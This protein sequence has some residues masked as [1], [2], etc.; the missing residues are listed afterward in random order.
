MGVP[1]DLKAAVIARGLADAAT[2]WR[3]LRGGRTNRVW[4]VGEVVVKLVLPDAANPVFANDATHE[5]AAL[6]ALQG[7]GIAPDPVALVPLSGADAVVYRYLPGRC[8][9][10]G[11]EAVAHLLRRL[12]ALPAPAALPVAPSTPEALAAQA[13]GLLRQAG[14]DVEP[15]LF[16]AVAEGTPDRSVLLHCD[17]VPGNLIAGDDGALRLIDWQCP[18]VGDPVV[19]LASFLSPAMQSL[20]GHAPLS[21]D[22]KARFLAAYGDEAVT[23]RYAR[24]APHF[25]RRTAA[26]CAWKA[27]RGDADY[28]RAKALELAAL[29]A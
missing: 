17:V 29:A 3:P 12:H 19:D 24:L 14:E 11:V 20:Y 18:A 6:A 9:D 23:A 16:A 26:Y 28:A 8:W 1:A 7:T 21:A 13:R 15:G 27:A 25:H 10:G 2:A 22:Q 5:F 4:R